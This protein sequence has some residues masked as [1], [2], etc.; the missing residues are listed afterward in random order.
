MILKEIE[1]VRQARESDRLYNIFVAYL[2]VFL[3][4]IVGEII[5]GIILFILIKAFKIPNNTPLSFSLSLIAGFLF[6]TLITFLWI[7]NVK[8]E[9]LL[10]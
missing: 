3:F 8:N 9:A 6:S 5:G 7:K 2:L 1:L 4:L 10:G